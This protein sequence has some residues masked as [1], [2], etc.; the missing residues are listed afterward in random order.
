MLARWLV[1]VLVL[2]LLFGPAWAKPVASPYYIDIAPYEEHIHHDKLDVRELFRSLEKLEPNSE[3]MLRPLGNYFTLLQVT[4]QSV[5]ADVLSVSLPT[6]QKLL[7]N[8]AA[9][10]S[11]ISSLQIVAG[12]GALAAPLE[13]LVLELALSPSLDINTRKEAL[14]TLKAIGSESSL[15]ALHQLIASKL[16]TNLRF[17]AMDTYLDL[18]RTRPSER[19]LEELQQVAESENASS[20]RLLA[21]QMLAQFS[22]A[23]DAPAHL[24]RL[25]TIL[26][27]TPSRIERW[28]LLSVVHRLPRSEL[29][30]EISDFYLQIAL[31]DSEPDVRSLAA[32]LLSSL[33]TATGSPVPP[34]TVAA[35]R[36]SL[37]EDN[38]W[39]FGLAL[40]I[41]ELS[42]EVPQ[43]FVESLAWRLI[44]DESQGPRLLKVL[45]R[46]GPK[47][48]RMTEA[49]ESFDFTKSNI[50]R[51]MIEETLAAIRLH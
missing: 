43:E 3:W 29:E 51:F 8:S 10:S 35:L 33:L 11:L 27:S 31:N 30:G 19:W 32:G 12:H 21:L 28:Q 17:R 50:P 26:A 4:G 20:E 47:A 1:S 23:D 34:E 45:T 6:L 14:V 40:A 5:P 49:L 24:T 37:Y 13:R 25:R 42:G 9:E 44:H 22:S 48:F 39:S 16:E 41:C 18:G 2:A 46:M 38:D 36:R 15:E 7:K